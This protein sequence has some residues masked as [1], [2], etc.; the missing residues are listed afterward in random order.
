[1]YSNLGDVLGLL[2]LNVRYIPLCKIWPTLM[3]NMEH[4]KVDLVLNEDL[5]FHGD[6]LDLL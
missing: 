6:L 3:L 4:R 1:M 2:I 5:H